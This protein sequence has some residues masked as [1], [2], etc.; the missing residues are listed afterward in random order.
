MNI[1]MDDDDDEYD[2]GWLGWVLKLNLD[3]FG[4]IAFPLL[5]LILH[6]RRLFI[7]NQSTSE[8]CKSESEKII[9]NLSKMKSEGEKVKVKMKMKSFSI[10]QSLATGNFHFQ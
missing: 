1:T 8:K 10:I 4:C 5:Q 3:Q 9:I 6:F 2:N 7:I